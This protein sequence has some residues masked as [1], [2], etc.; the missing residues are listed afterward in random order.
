MDEKWKTNSI[1]YY[2]S[3]PW[4]WL[5]SSQKLTD[6]HFPASGD[7]TIPYMDSSGLR[8]PADS[9]PGGFHS[10]LSIPPNPC[11]QPFFFTNPL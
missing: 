2:V 3:V 6:L 8:L 5:F 7:V 10:V 1:S 4:Y 9:L 11:H